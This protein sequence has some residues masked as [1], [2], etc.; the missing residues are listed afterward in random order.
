MKAEQYDEKLLK[1]VARVLKQKD[2]Y[3]NSRTLFK[4]GEYYD[5][6]LESH[7]K[8][9]LSK[10]TKNQAE[11]GKKI[12][13][14]SKS[15]RGHKA[16]Y[17][18]E[19]LLY[20]HGA[21]KV[22]TILN[23]P[24]GTFLKIQKEISKEL[25]GD[26]GVDKVFGLTS[27]GKHAPVQAVLINPLPTTINVEKSGVDAFKS[28]YHD[29]LIEAS[30]IE[31]KAERVAKQ[32]EILKKYRTTLKGWKNDPRYKGVEFTDFEIGKHPSKT[33]KNWNELGPAIK[34]QL[35]ADY[36][37]TGISPKTTKARSIFQVA[38]EGG[39]Q[40]WK[41]LDQS[42]KKNLIKL[43]GNKASGG[44]VGFQGAGAV[45]VGGVKCGQNR[46][47]EILQKGG[48]TTGEKNLVQKIMRG[49]GAMLKGLANPRQF[50][51]LRALL[52]PEAMLFYA[53]IEG[54]MVSYD[55]LAKGIPWKEGIS[56]SM[57]GALTP[58]TTQEAQIEDMREKGMINTPAMKKWATGIENMAEIDRM[59]QG[60]E[61]SQSW[62]T[63]TATGLRAIEKM[64]KNI[65][66]KENEF[67]SWMGDNEIS[68]QALMPG[69]GGEIEFQKALTERDAIEGATAPL[70]F[71]RG[72]VGA[73]E[74]PP[75]ITERIGPR[76][77]GVVKEELKPL[78]Q[79]FDLPETYEKVS[80]SETPLPAESFQYLK[81]YMRQ[82]G[83]LKPRDD[84]PQGLIDYLQ[85]EEKWKQ[86]LELP[87]MRGT[88]F[89]T[90]GRVGFAMGRR[91]FLGWLASVFGGIAGIK[92][93]LIGFGKGKGKGT[94]AIKVGD[95]IIK[96]TE[97]MPDWFIPLVNRV[98]K[99]GTDVSQKLG[100]VKREI[101]HTKKLGEGK[102]ADEVTVYQDMNTG[103]VRV[104]YESPH[105][106]GEAP[107]Q[108]E[109]R[110]GEVIESGKHAG[111]KTKSE[112]D[113][114]ESEPVGRA[115]GPDDYSIEW[116]GENVVG[117]VDDLM[118]DTSKLKQFAT[119]KKPTMGEI[120]ETSK[121]RKAV[122]EVHKDESDYI[123][124][125]QGEYVDYDD[126]LPDIDDLD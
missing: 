25:V 62:S 15:Y 30:K 5:G 16:G 51:S 10:P 82:E 106:M 92:S 1:E 58:W 13:G 32:K 89:N 72:D 28:A 54:G 83:L 27:S 48:G 7:Y 37:A 97:G 24:E 69:S 70:R 60:L 65:E 108:L 75:R 78:Q 17:A 94:V 76:K 111:K 88:Q 9:N 26:T 4:L 35:I 113:A 64:K 85:R 44:R 41:N 12:I 98:T 40:T 115:Q 114:V 96:S 36:K 95:K 57:I 49:G 121:K 23:L 122:Q 8:V 63:P 68:M 105:N 104:V 31:N 52:G 117:N 102:F 46:L 38:E 34:K 71:F 125:K 84:L 74:L 47:R 77:M 79:R 91:A 118:S 14:S 107:I 21:R 18:L 103:N 33:I 66:Q 53:G 119:K 87:G 50:F 61:A 59:Y 73:E 123:V 116:D 2:V 45:A 126:Y 86:N 55:K 109:Y 101:V 6:S 29:Q 11:I 100:T 39:S 22:D 67:M 120:V 93:G 112:F 42:L 81:D 124:K 43:C 19:K 20:Q 90:G 80:T 110:A 99:E 3:A 56:E